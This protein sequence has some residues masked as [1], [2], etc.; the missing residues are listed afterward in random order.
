MMGLQL[1]RFLSVA[2]S[3]KL[4]LIHKPPRYFELI[5]T[6]EDPDNQLQVDLNATHV[7]FNVILESELE[8]V[9]IPYD[10]VEKWTY[11][12]VVDVMK[13]LVVM[14]NIPPIRSFNLTTPQLEFKKLEAVFK[15]HKLVLST[16]QELCEMSKSLSS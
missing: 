15:T 8:L 4:A 13:V 5:K 10:C 6:F 12:S 9:K 14:T 16:N 11:S 1:F 2:Q 3:W 7:S